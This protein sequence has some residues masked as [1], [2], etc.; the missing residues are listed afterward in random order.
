MLSAHCSAAVAKS[1]SNPVLQNAS[2]ASLGTQ[3]GGVGC[4][5]GTRHELSDGR[6][7]DLAETCTRHQD[8]RCFWD[9][10]GRLCIDDG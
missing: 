10:W 3:L 2:R 1:S 5:T 7:S 4:I 9:G 8:Q 6:P